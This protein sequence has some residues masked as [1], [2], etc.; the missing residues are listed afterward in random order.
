METELT[1][2]RESITRRLAEL[3]PERRRAIEALLRERKH[4]AAPSAAIPRRQPS[5]KGPMSYAQQRLWM[6]DQI[7]PNSPFYNESFIERLRFRLDLTALHRALNEIVRR[8]ESLRTTFHVENGEPVQV[9]APALAIPLPLADM[10][11]VPAS[12]RES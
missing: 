11:I 1:P 7:Q 8:H 12:R 10:R 2:E 6:L 3:S 5:A 4:R 9:I